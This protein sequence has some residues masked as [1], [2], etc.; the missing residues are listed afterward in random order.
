V[1]FKEKENLKIAVACENGEVVKDLGQTEQ[2]MLY[3]TQDGK[4]LKQKVVDVKKD[5]ADSFGGHFAQNGVDVLICN[6]LTNEEAEEL[7]N[8]GVLTYAG[9]SGSGKEL[10]GRLLRQELFYDPG[11]HLSG[12]GLGCERCVDHRDYRMEIAAEI[13][14]ISGH[15]RFHPGHNRV[16]GETTGHNQRVSYKKER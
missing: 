8:A 5:R 3:D 14:R 11:A 1:E 2:L 6:E 16:G 9:N 7:R 13:G 10:V 4:I 12:E 15:N